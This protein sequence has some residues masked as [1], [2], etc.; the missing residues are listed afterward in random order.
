VK[1]APVIAELRRRIPDGEHMMIH[2]GQQHY[3]R[4]QVFPRELGV[5]ERD[6]MPGVGSTSQAPQTV[7][8]M[9]RIQPVLVTLVSIASRSCEVRVTRPGATMVTAT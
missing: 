9:E 3:D 2:T 1:M 4:S 5:G 6:H 7:G 8:V